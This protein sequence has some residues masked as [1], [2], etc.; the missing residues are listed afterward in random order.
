LKKGTRSTYPVSD[1]R[2]ACGG[3]ATTAVAVTNTPLPSVV[4]LQRVTRGG[5]VITCD[6]I[7]LVVVK[8][9]ASDRVEVAFSV[10][11]SHFEDVVETTIT[12]NR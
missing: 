8:T 12:R 11:V 7:E 2:S 5:V 3:F 1:V 4:V 6:P 10:T 9:T